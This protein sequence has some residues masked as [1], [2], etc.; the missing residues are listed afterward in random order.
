MNESES[1]AT[2]SRKFAE[3][4]DTFG[5]LRID[6]CPNGDGWEDTLAGA[7]PIRPAS[8]PGA[9]ENERLIVEF[10]RVATEAGMLKDPAAH[11]PL[12]AWF[13][14]LRTQYFESAVGTDLDGRLARYRFGS[15]ERAVAASVNLCAAL[16][17]AFTGPVRQGGAQQTP[18][19][20]PAQKNGR[21]ASHPSRARRRTTK[22]T[23][24]SRRRTAWLDQKLSENAAWN[25]TTLCREAGIAEN[26]Y[27]RYRSGKPSTH[28]TTVR[29]G[30][31]RAFKCPV[32]DVPE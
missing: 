11:D 7:G 10:K 13:E 26:T 30:L 27:R 5:M 23:E 21:A 14:A 31:A 2:L 16:E 9:L 19:Q 20:P 22:D 17:L 12:H 3:V 18:N 29:G 25:Q 24:P 28:D 32:Q 1:W 8:I 4:P 15:V 6:Y